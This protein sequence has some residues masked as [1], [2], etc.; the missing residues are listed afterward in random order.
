MFMGGR[1]LGL[2]L[3][4][5]FDNH[6]LFKIVGSLTIFFLRLMVL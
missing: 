4:R 2:E 3:R 5:E 6:F 1:T